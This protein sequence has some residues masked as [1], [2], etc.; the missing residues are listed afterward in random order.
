MRD[1]I[2]LRHLEYFVAVAEEAHFTRAA[3]RLFIAQPSLSAAIAQLE[4][5]LGTT[6]VDRTDRRRLRLTTSGETLLAHARE[7]IAAVD[8]AID[9]TRA[10]ARADA[11]TLRLGYDDGEPL[12]RRPGVLGAALRAAGID[13]TFRR[14]P[15]GSEGA[16]VRAG[17]VDAALVRLP[18]DDRGLSVRVLG[19]EPRW[20]CVPAGHRLARRRSLRITDL[21]GV[22]V[23]VP[24]GGTPAWIDF[25]RG[26]PRPDGHRPPEGPATYGP[27]DTFDTVAA[28]GVICFVPASM[29]STATS[30]E[31]RFAPV[32]GLAPVETAVVWSRRRA[33]PAG[34]DRLAA[35][36]ADLLRSIA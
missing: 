3:E 14:L 9:A 13:V 12:A 17:E 19:S 26:L 11:T 2:E 35:A 32:D 10:A 15:W 36:A 20:V 8:G 18:I 27:E 25:W 31:L 29:V 34:L 24:T 5:R 33:R 16:A 21:R 22:P 23:V 4:R 30:P 1:G 6:L 7:V 28:G